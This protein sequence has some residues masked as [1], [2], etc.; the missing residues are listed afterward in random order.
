VCVYVGVCALCDAKFEPTSACQVSK[1]YE[2]LLVTPT[3]FRA[4]G[5]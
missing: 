2:L 4:M 5:K 1:A 3:Y